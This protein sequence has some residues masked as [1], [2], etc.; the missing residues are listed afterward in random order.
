MWWRCIA[1]KT[2]QRCLFPEFI[3]LFLSFCCELSLLTQCQQDEMKHHMQ[4]CEVRLLT[5]KMQPFLC[6]VY[7]VQHQNI[8]RRISGDC[9]D[10][11][12]NP[13]VAHKARRIDHEQF[14]FFVA[15]SCLCL[16]NGLKQVYHKPKSQHCTRMLVN[17]KC[18]VHRR[19]PTPV[20]L[21][22]L[23]V[24]QALPCAFR[25]V[26]CVTRSGSKR[27]KLAVPCPIMYIKQH[28]SL[29]ATS[30]SAFLPQEYKYM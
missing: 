9:Q 12:F 20:P 17:C 24:H 6:G 4:G 21:R 2:R 3:T 29:E 11:N 19:V 27:T 8:S 30:M 14:C 5:N 23:A 1:L 18:T 22:A 7:M 10:R 26:C 25:H 16:H 15:A 13:V 28:D